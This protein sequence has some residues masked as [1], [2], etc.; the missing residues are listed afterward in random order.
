LGKLPVSSYPVTLPYFFSG[1]CKSLAPEYAKAAKAMAEWNPP[2]YL[3]KVDATEHKEVAG[4]FDVKGF[5]TL[6]FF[7]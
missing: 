7:R 1:H 3:A 5:P 4:R 6:K 2:Q